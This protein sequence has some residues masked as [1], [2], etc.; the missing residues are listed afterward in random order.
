[1]IVGGHLPVIVAEDG[2]EILKLSM[3]AFE[4]SQVAMPSSGTA[5]PLTSVPISW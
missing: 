2:I 4:R 3:R 1:M 5:T